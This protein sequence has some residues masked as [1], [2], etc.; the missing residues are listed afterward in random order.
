MEEPA[1]IHKTDQDTAGQ[2]EQLRE[3]HQGREEGGN[4][5]SRVEGQDIGRLGQTMDV[6]RNGGQERMHKVDKMDGEGNTQEGKTGNL[7]GG[8]FGVG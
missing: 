6:G 3:G 4:I 8:A 1:L 7:E 5:N 2:K